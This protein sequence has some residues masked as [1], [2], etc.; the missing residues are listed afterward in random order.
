MLL[1]LLA[2]AGEP[3]DTGD[4]DRMHYDYDG[5]TSSWS[6]DDLEAAI[7]AFTEQGTPG[8]YALGQHMLDAMERGDETCPGEGLSFEL[9][10]PCTSRSGFTFFGIGWTL[11]EERDEATGLVTAYRHGADLEFLDP[12]G[13]RYFGAGEVEAAVEVFEDGSLTFTHEGSGSWQ[14][15]LDTGWLGSGISLAYTMEGEQD[16][17]GQ[18]TMRWSGGLGIGA[19]TVAFDD[20]GW[21][22]TCG[23][24][25]GTLQVRDPDGYWLSWTP[26]SDCAPCGTASADGQDLGELCLDLEDWGEAMLAAWGPL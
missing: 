4:S 15:E 3:A 6:L 5:G 23:G 20:F 13:K 24:P 17:G 22:D 11:E 1:L 2:C 7:G 25:L 19:H 14:D 10:Q 16:P 21:T 18:R 8:P 26:E 12:D 9:L